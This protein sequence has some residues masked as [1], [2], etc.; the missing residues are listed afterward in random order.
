L[1]GLAYCP[2]TKKGC[3]GDTRAYGSPK[4]ADVPV[5]K[6]LCGAQTSKG[7]RIMFAS[8]FPRRGE[9]A[10][11]PRP[12]PQLFLEALEERQL[13]SG[14]QIDVYKFLDLNLNGSRDPGEPGI[15]GVQ[16]QLYRSDLSIVDNKYTLA[17]DFT[18]PNVDEAGQQWFTNLPA[19]L[20]YL[21]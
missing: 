20:Y 17:D 12:S 19:G 9:R 18:T 4:T 8:L 1:R 14:G 3:R 15:A 5:Q 11:T 16:F 6:R 13:L 21:V 2:P 7:V 10:R